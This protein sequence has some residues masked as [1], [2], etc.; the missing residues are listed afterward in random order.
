MLVV[1]ACVLTAPL[2]HARGPSPYL[3]LN[4]SPS[5]ERQIE[6]VLILAGK[7]VMRRPIAAAVVLDALPAAC[8]L[9]RALCEDVRRYLQRYMGK[10]A[11]TH[12]RPEVGITSGDSAATLPNQHG[13]PADSTWQVAASGFFQ[14]N[15][16]VILNAGGIAY[17]GNATATGSFLSV[18]FDFAQLDVGFR[19]HWLSPFTDSSSLIGTQAPTMPSIT[20]SNYEPISPLGIGYEIFAAQMSR[21]NEILFEETTT[22]GEPRLA[23]VQLGIEPTPG[24]AFA[25]NRITQ[26]GGGARNQGT[27][28]QF[29]DALTESQNPVT[30][31]SGETEEFGNQ[32]ASIT[33]SL[34]AHTKIPFG[35]HVEYAGEDNAYAAGYRLG[36]TN[37]SLGVDLPKLWKV[38]DATFE[39]SE[40]QNS[41]Y[42]HHIYPRGLTNHGNVL[43]HWFGDQREFGNAIGGNSEMLALGWHRRPDQYL[44]ATYRTMKLDPRWV[45]DAAVPPYDR[46]HSLGVSFS[47][48]WRGFPVE[49]ELSGGQDVFGESFA[50][51]F[52]S[53]DFSG[54][55]IVSS[56]IEG[57]VGPDDVELFV[58]LGANRSEVTKLLAIGTP[59]DPA[60]RGNGM[61]VGIGARR[62]L[63]KRGDIGMRLELDQ[64]DGSAL[65]SLRA[66]D[67]QY[68]VTKRIALGAFGG[69]ARYDYG[70]ATNGYVWGAGVQ[71]RD[72]LPKWDIG[73]DVRHYEKLNRDKTLPTDPVPSAETHPRLYIDIDAMNFYISRRW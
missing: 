47:A 5:I 59:P 69:F 61:H 21:Q 8:E 54:G 51:L 34:L 52:G 53:I 64:V 62:G 3:P 46:L 49:V 57:A 20:L 68:R 67:Y 16:Y 65:L 36:A 33:A 22:S 72:V 17:E 18:G 13:R 31:A 43:G 37:L 63:S 39:I 45:R 55:S 24:Y 32:V 42:V 26:Y 71:F 25:V 1:S 41:W 11:V 73:F 28:S 14:L 10:Y 23:G 2:T 70:L 44:R 9:D 58:D 66:L 40:W 19:D 4:M 12:A 6:R 7:P 38:F 50:R 29:I 60:A 48:N 15:D 35:V 30:D 27:L 56:A